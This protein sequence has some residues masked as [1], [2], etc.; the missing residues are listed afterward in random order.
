MSRVESTMNWETY[1]S[2]SFTPN[3]GRNSDEQ[4][5]YARDVKE[6]KELICFMGIL[7]VI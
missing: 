4:L 7:K 1:L 5:A 3:E 6:T 2:H